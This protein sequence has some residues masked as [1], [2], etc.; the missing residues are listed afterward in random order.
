MIIKKASFIKS[1]YDESEFINDNLKKIAF[2]G[3]SNVGKSSLINRLTNNSH[4]ARV[5]KTPGKTVSINYFLINDTFYFVDMPGYGY[6]KGSQEKV[7]TFSDISD[8]YIK[9]GLLDY[10]FLL[11][12]SRRVT[13]D[14]IS[15]MNYLK[16]YK[17]PTKVILT[18]IDTLKRNDI[19]KRLLDS[20]NILEVDEKDIIL[21]SSNTKE[22]MDNLLSN[23]ENILNL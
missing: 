5:S 15:M 17:I 13:S 20:K 18:K 14:D 11:V 23:L 10:I 19:K 21:F 16:E 22:G 7:S 9:S 1:V 12:D 8:K 3:R 2:I 4:L 6:A